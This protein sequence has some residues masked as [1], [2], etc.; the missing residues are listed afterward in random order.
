MRHRNADRLQAQLQGL[1]AAENERRAG[2][3]PRVPTAEDDHRKCDEAAS[4]RLDDLTEKLR[5][6]KLQDI[7]RVTGVCPI[8]EL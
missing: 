4:S 1:G 8:R 5:Q 2:D 3:A 7:K 6:A